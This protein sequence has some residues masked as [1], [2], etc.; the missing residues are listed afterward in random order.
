MTKIFHSIFYLFL[1]VFGAFASDDCLDYKLNPNITIK[2]PIW[3]KSVVQP[4]QKMDVLHGDV[5][6][7][8]VDEFEITADITSIE[9]GFCVALKDIDAT[10]GYADFLVQIDI[11]HR[12]ESCSYNAILQHEDEHIRAYLSVIDDDQ[13][14][15]TRMENQMKIDTYEVIKTDNYGYKYSPQDLDI[16]VPARQQYDNA[17]REYRKTHG[18]LFLRKLKRLII[19]ITSCV[20]LGRQTRGAYRTWLKKV[21]HY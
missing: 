5:I 13:L 1:F 15:A 19:K 16:D 4:L 11:S 8:L 9:D 3:S 18:N 17:L 20:V 12:P 6:A 7:T 14:I 21:L 10:I 2:S